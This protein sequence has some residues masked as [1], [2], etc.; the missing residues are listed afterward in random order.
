MKTIDTLAILNSIPVSYKL[1]EKSQLIIKSRFRL[2]AKNMR[3]LNSQITVVTG[4]SNLTSTKS[5][6]RM[7]VEWA[8]C[9]SHQPRSEMCKTGVISTEERLVRDKWGFHPYGLQ[10]TLHIC[11]WLETFIDEYRGRKNP[12][13]QNGHSA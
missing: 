12:I 11:W 6:F 8:G 9:T 5:L 2:C 7:Y 4:G 13:K 10:D 1:S 3:K